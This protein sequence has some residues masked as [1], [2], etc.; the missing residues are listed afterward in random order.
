[1]YKLCN[2]KG[3][4]SCIK[5]AEDV[6]YHLS[7]V[8]KESNGKGYTTRLEYIESIGGKKIYSPENKYAISVEVENGIVVYYQ[9]NSM[10][11]ALFLSIYQQIEKY[12]RT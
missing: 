12:L 11:L 1:M 7:S 8:V 3:N 2:I 6:E 10:K 5:N 9:K 4:S